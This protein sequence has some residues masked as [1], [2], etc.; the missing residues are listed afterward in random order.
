VQLYVY[1]KKWTLKV[2][3]LYQ[4]NHISYFNKI[5][6]ICYL[7]THI[8]S[9]KVW[10]KSVLH[11]WNTEFFLGG[12]FLLAHPVS[13]KTLLLNICIYRL[14]HVKFN[15]TVSK[16]HLLYCRIS[17]THKS[18]AEKL[19][20]Y[21]QLPITGAISKA[22]KETLNCLILSWSTDSLGC[23]MYISCLNSNV[24]I[25]LVPINKSIKLKKKN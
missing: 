24:T 19:L 10:L 16:L 11:G 14:T 20:N 7:N 21:K 12:C 22:L 6:R 25:M 13:D 18:E 23:I 5:C 15:I 2:K 4:L 3:L 1:L 9:L 8:Q 17:S